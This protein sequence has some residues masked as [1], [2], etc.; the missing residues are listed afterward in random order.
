MTNCDNCGEHS[1]A[2]LCEDCNREH[3][4]KGFAQSMNEGDKADEYLF[5]HYVSPN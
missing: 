3:Y 2:F 5:R 1:T 4:N